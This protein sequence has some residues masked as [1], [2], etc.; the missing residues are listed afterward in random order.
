LCAQPLWAEESGFHTYAWTTLRSDKVLG[1][2][3]LY[4]SSATAAAG[5]GLQYTYGNL[6]SLL[7][8]NIDSEDHVTLDGS[9]LEYSVGIAT[10]GIGAVDRNWSF[11]PRTSLILPKNAGPITSAYMK[12]EADG[13][14]ASPWLS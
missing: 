2:R 6:S 12:L 14:P 10:F 4:G 8:L 13:A 7:S 3:Q 9:Y 1:Q 5:I 11:S